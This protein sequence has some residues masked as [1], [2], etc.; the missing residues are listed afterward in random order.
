MNIGDGAAGV[1]EVRTK[2]GVMANLLGVLELENR[3]S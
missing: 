1:K 2:A 3:L